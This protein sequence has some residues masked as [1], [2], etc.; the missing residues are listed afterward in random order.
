MNGLRIFIVALC[1]PSCAS[2][3]VTSIQSAPAK[4]EKC[5]LAVFT[6]ER[7]IHQPFEVV[8]FIDAMS[9]GHMLAD[10]TVAGAIHAANAK[11]C[12][13]GADALLIHEA[14]RE[15]ENFWGRGFALLKAIRYKSSSK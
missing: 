7:E 15:S 9:A 4:D 1:L 5:K 3:G 2:V 11:A 14:R 8:C 6:D 12:G 13:C 10:T